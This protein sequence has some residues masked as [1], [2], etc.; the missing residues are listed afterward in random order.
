MRI[1]P[2]INQGNPRFR[3]NVQMPGYRKRLFFRTYAEA[4]K[5]AQATG[6]PV[7]LGKCRKPIPA[8]PDKAAPDKS[9]GLFNPYNLIFGDD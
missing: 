4:A 5:F 7:R 9:G 6:G 8:P 2:T 1:T 3:V